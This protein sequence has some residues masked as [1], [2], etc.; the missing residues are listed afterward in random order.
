MAAPEECP[1]Q[2]HFDDSGVPFYYNEATEES[3]WDV[4]PAWKDHFEDLDKQAAADGVA[5]VG[6]SADA[7]ENGHAAGT[8]AEHGEEEVDAERAAAAEQRQVDDA[9]GAQALLGLAQASGDQHQETPEQRDEEES[10]GT[11]GAAA[12]QASGDKGSVSPLDQEGERQGSGSAEGSRAGSLAGGTPPYATTPPA[13]DDERRN[14]DYGDANDTNR[15]SEEDSYAPADGGAAATCPWI[16]SFDED[17]K[18]YFYYNEVTEESSWD[19]PEEYERFHAAQAASADDGAAVQ[20]ATAAQAADSDEH[21]EEEYYQARSP[22]GQGEES[23]AY[24]EE[25]DRRA[26]SPRYSDP[27]E[28]EE[29]EEEDEGGRRSSRS[30]SSRPSDHPSAAAAS[31]RQTRSSS[32]KDAGHHTNKR[33]S[34]NNEKS[35]PSPEMGLSFPAF[36][37]DYSPNHDGEWQVNDEDDPEGG[38]ASGS[39]RD[40]S[41][42]ATPF[43]VSMSPESEELGSAP[44]T[45][46]F[47]VG[48]LSPV[49]DHSGVTAG[50]DGQHPGSDKAAGDRGAVKKKSKAAEAEEKAQYT[51]AERA[52]MVESAE[53][54]VAECERRLE[55]KDAIMEVDF[56]TRVTAYQSARER[57]QQLKDGIPN[58]L[59]FVKETK[60]AGVKKLVAGYKGYAQQASL[61]NNWLQLA[62]DGKE[63][64][65]N[66]M[67]QQLKI[68]IKTNFDAKKVD[69]LLDSSM[70]GWLTAMQD[71]DGWRRTL[72]ELAREHRASALLRFVLKQLSDMGYH[73]EIASVINQT[74]LFSVFNGVLKDALA[75]IPGG[76]EVEA[77]EALADLKRMC[78][79]TSY[80]FMY[81][82]Q[83]LID[84]ERAAME[85]STRASSSLESADK[86]NGENGS[87]GSSRKRGREDSKP[88]ASS[89]VAGDK[90]AEEKGG[91]GG[92][93]WG[94]TAAA[95]K[96]KRLRQELAKHMYLVGGRADSNSSSPDGGRGPGSFS[97]GR[98][99]SIGGGIG[100]GGAGGSSRSE[101]NGG[102]SAEDDG[103]A[104]ASSGAPTGA[105][106]RGVEMG[107]SLRLPPPATGAAE[108]AAKAASDAVVSLLGQAGGG[109]ARRTG[110]VSDAVET[111]V[112][113]FRLKLIARACNQDAAAA[114]AAA[115]ETAAEQNANHQRP[116]ALLLRHPTVMDIF[117]EALFHP[118]HRSPSEDL[119][120][121]CCVLLAYASCVRV[122][123]LDT[124]GSGGDGVVG[125][126]DL[127]ELAETSHALMQAAG[128]C[129][130]TSQLASLQRRL[131]P[132]AGHPLVSLGVLRWVHAQVSTEAF[133]STPSFLSYAPVFLTLCGQAAEKHPP[134][135]PETFEIMKL[136]LSASTAPDTPPAAKAKLKQSVLLRMADLV[137]K[138]ETCIHDIVRF[139]IAAGKG[140]PKSPPLTIGPTNKIHDTACA[141]LPLRPPPLPFRALG[142]LR[143]HAAGFR[144][145]STCGDRVRFGSDAGRIFP[146]EDCRGGYPKNRAKGERSQR[147][148]PDVPERHG[149]SDGCSACEA[150]FNCLETNGQGALR[151]LCT[152]LSQVSATRFYSGGEGVDG[153]AASRSGA[154]VKDRR[155][156][157]A[158]MHKKLEQGELQDRNKRKNIVTEP[159]SLILTPGDGDVSPRHT[160]KKKQDR[161]PRKIFGSIWYFCKIAFD[162]TIG[163][164]TREVR[165][166]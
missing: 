124:G 73:R 38:K 26:A 10:G 67:L 120:A 158:A 1:W 70:P 86:A 139:L 30:P 89:K 112:S 59:A 125:T 147:L 152:I 17:S 29:D 159:F 138:G 63:D 13:E 8:G 100:S 105:F 41:N 65:E 37:D 45:P 94:R 21:S 55:E 156:R 34:S 98:S 102:I 145:S 19:K 99:I 150:G 160:A 62:T 92:G 56:S 132:F 75:R 131:L 33:S 161:A 35:S 128:E 91:S 74:D 165:G 51:E 49:V 157:K 113:S 90:K 82:Q 109:G 108:K 27:E 101:L 122:P 87:G 53:R 14:G 93:D 28:E 151:G 85:D 149:G 164:L 66:L 79:S 72:I 96:Y 80:M 44:R 129:F 4:P 111:L 32:R 163:A 146:G 68:L 130:V 148:L 36:G 42:G 119:R 77:I 155:G 16:K 24:G 107:P 153:T 57:L 50:D 97:F 133:V 25:E 127:A 22:E 64:T 126:V 143:V 78:C 142:A 162:W 166:F 123:V 144:L 136:M 83:L 154:S 117:L 135:R 20:A 12:G 11:G 95:R 104:G 60:N 137:V 48:E 69:T 39:P 103:S 114:E 47:A 118:S 84:L 23:G 141:A 58:R 3:E 2:R 40:G 18:T 54:E 43:G 110:V 71:D 121:G 52:Q 46:G 15:A 9:E 88:S 134:Q 5:D 115:T 106:L 7:S 140:E 76:D 61:V 81:S 116:P 6:A 31:S